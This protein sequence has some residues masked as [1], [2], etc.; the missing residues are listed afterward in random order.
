MV[1]AEIESCHFVQCLK[2]KKTE[3]NGSSYR[4]V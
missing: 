4:D 2:E 1:V 3:T